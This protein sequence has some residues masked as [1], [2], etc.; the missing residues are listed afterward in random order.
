LVAAWSALLFGGCQPAKESATTQPGPA[1]AVAA[2][3]PVPEVKP[4]VNQAPQAI[5]IKA[6]STEGL[7]DSQGNHWLPDQGFSEGETI[8][9]PDLAITNTV[10]PQI[11]RS[12]RYSMS[13][14]TQ[15]LPNGKYIVKLHFC[16]T[17]EGITG[18]GQRVFTF[19]VAGHEFKDFDVW[20]KAGGSQRAYVETVPVEITNGKLEITFTPNI[21]NPQINGLEII[22][23][24][25]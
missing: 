11:Y 21:E 9:R 1:V 12:E 6:G 10:D 24:A 23:A 20:V 17:F 18:P 7:T 15:P 5:R 22:P 25:D 4:A 13:G 19:N 2:P 8:E 16:E 14:F 3:M